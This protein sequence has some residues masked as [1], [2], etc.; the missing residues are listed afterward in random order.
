[1]LTYN[2]ET[3]QR[4]AAMG[5]R[6]YMSPGARRKGHN[7]RA[8]RTAQVQNSTDVVKVHWTP[9]F[10]R[11][12]VRIYVCSAQ[13]GDANLPSKLNDSTNLSRFV[14]QI[15][16]EKVETHLNSPDFCMPGGRGLDGLARDMR[17]RC[18]EV[19]KRKGQRIP[20]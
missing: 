20:K 15:L 1:M 8:P 13:P 2:S 9:V 16:P 17:A 14:S 12:K 10:A 5:T 3:E 6:K 18:A 11:G 19:V 7:L 4:V